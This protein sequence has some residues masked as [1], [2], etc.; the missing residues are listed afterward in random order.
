MLL[1]SA[2]NCPYC[3]R[4]RIGLEEKGLLWET[5]EVDL[6]NKPPELVALNPPGGAVPVLVVDGAVIPESLVILQYLEERFPAVPLLPPDP[7]DRARARLL[8]D[9]V[10]SAIGPAGYKL[11]RGAPEDRPAAE[12]VVREALRALEPQVPEAGYL[13]GGFS[14]A[15]LAIAPFVARLPAHLRGEVLGLPRLARWEALVFARPSVAR[16]TAAR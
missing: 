3:M 14:L 16:Q 12:D 1:W 5:R 10:T 9:R 15:D 4:V 8:A 13:V 7:A 11:A 6:A 2:W